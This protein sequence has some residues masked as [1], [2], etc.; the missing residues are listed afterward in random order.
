MC[1]CVHVGSRAAVM[2]VQGGVVEGV[3]CLAGIFIGV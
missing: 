1:A 3:D 2:V